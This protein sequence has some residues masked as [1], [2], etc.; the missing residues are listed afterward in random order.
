MGLVIVTNSLFFC[1]YKKTKQ[2]QKIEKPE[3]KIKKNVI[4]KIMFKDNVAQL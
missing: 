3:T 1:F 4:Y 2:K